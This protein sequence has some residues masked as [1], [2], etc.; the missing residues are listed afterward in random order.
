MSVK[1]NLKKGAWYAV[2]NTTMIMF[3]LLSVILV[4]RIFGP[5]SLG[6]LSLIQAISAMLLFTVVLGLDHI[7]VRDIARDPTNKRYLSTVFI[8]QAIAWALHAVLVFFVLWLLSE[9][10]VES[11]VIVIFFAVIAGTYFSRATVLKLYFQATNQ[12][13]KIG[14]SA[15]Y[16]RLLGLLYLGWALFNEY[17]YEYIILFIPIQTFF[18][19]F[20]LLRF[21]LK[22]QKEPFT[23]YFDTKLVKKLLTE[24]LPLLASAALFPIFMQADILL[25]ATLMS[26]H[27]VG[28]YSASSR[29]VTQLVFLGHIIT[30]TFYL[31]LS[32]RI[33]SNSPDQ[34]QFTQG[35]IKI[36]FI[37]GFSMSLV[38]SLMSEFIIELLYGNSFQGAGE[39]LAILAW[40]WT[41]IFPAALFSRLLVLK[42]L[43]RFELIKSLI[44]AIF[45]LTANYLLI[46][47]MGITGAAIISILSYFIADYLI[48]SV[49]KPTRGMFTLATMSVF[50]VFFRPSKTM[51]DIRHT[52]GSK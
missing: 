15:V 9:Q 52:L 48:Y 30:M 2:E 33:D 12:P 20:M 1:Y 31:A 23:F 11:D 29:L 21:Y 47:I 39:V 45:S 36:L 38:V 25:I 32:K 5:E 6:K 37:F 3:G 51:Q 4:A 28:I 13:K 19:F 16:S 42:G 27:D 26:E 46:P 24:A 40:T 49:F 41:F 22:E 35:L 18:H 8:L 10:G 50:E 44:V 34:I 17:N 43:M 7:I 14:T